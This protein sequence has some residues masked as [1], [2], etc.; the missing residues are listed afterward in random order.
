M[1]RFNNVL[2]ELPDKDEVVLARV[3]GK[4]SSILYVIL[5]WDGEAFKEAVTGQLSFRREDVIGWLP[6]SDLDQL[7]LRKVKS[8]K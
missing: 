2:K 4:D 3:H 6:L 7:E 8:R 5:Y 1:L